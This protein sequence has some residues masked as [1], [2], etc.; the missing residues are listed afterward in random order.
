[1]CLYY[2]N[3]LEKNRRDYST[4]EKTDVLI[5]TLD[6]GIKSDNS[7]RPDIIISVM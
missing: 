2:L 7:S 6:R 1:M 4:I 5:V 3:R